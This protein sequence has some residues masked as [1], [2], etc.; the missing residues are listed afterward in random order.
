MTDAADVKSILVGLN[1][2]RG[3]VF[4]AKLT[5]ENLLSF[6]DADVTRCPESVVVDADQWR[7]QLENLNDTDRV[8][9]DQ[10]LFCNGCFVPRN[11]VDAVGVGLVALQ[12][13][14]TGRFDDPL[15]LVPNY[16]RP[17][18]AEEKIRG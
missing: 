11:S 7:L 16:L 8:T 9:G 14:K 17:S 4:T 10:K 6:G 12:L 5:R 2:Y 15:K 1:A 3:Q 13:A 18:A